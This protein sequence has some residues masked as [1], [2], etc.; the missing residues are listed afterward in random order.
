M[1][2]LVELSNQLEDFPEQQLVQMSQDPNS[3]YPSY[4][5]L[6]EIQRRNQMRKMYDAQQPKP[7]TTVAEEVVQEFSGQQG[8]QGAMAQ[9]PGPQDAFPPSDMGNMA[10]PSP[11]QMMA[12]G[13]LTGSDGGKPFFKPFMYPLGSKGNPV[14]KYTSKEYPHGVPESNMSETKQILFERKQ[15]IMDTLA[16]RRIN[17]SRMKN[18]NEELRAINIELAGN[19]NQGI[20][21]NTRKNNEAMRRTLQG[22]RGEDVNYRESLYDVQNRQDNEKANQDFLRMKFLES[23]G[24]GRAGL[25]AYQAGGRTGFQVGGFTPT[26]QNPYPTGSEL[27]SD[28]FTSSGADI[29]L[30]ETIPIESLSESQRKEILEKSEKLSTS[31]KI[32]YGLGAASLALL[33]TPAPGA[34]IAAGA[35]KLL[36]LG[37]RAG[38]GLKKIYDAKRAQR[39]LKAGQ[40]E[41]NRKGGLPATTPYNPNTVLQTGKEALRR[42]LPYKIIG[43]STLAGVTIPPALDY[44]TND[45][46]VVDDN[47]LNNKKPT[48]QLLDTILN[49]DKETKRKGLGDPLDLARLGFTIMG[50][51]NTSELASGLGG[52]VSDIQGRDKKVAEQEYIRAQTDALVANAN[53]K[54]PDQYY[55]LASTYGAQIKA[56]F[57]AGKTEQAAALS[58]ELSQ[59]Q[60]AYAKSLGLNILTQEEQDAAALQALGI[61]NA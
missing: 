58:N 36:Q 18:L 44:L 15:E 60:A 41:L 34:R 50:A 2:N 59:I 12:G 43:G 5:V 24:I 48:N 27:V 57:D 54:L 3:M 6:S 52:L 29:G 26:G 7:Q 33:A 56:L 39:L 16:D 9:S 23:A 45:T 49:K 32:Q 55:K 38:S 37:V 53:M 31:E 11:M 19:F 14:G 17:K 4:L 35:T 61:G 51:R 10:P 28:T 40:R 21:R 1:A 30:S 42:E 46:N 47:T 8:L 13:G 22:I 25:P 20:T